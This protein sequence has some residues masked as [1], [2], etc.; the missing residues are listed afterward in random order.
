VK[1]GDQADR[2]AEEGSAW[3]ALGGVALWGL[4]LLFDL[5]GTVKGLRRWVLATAPLAPGVP[6][7]G[8]L[9]AGRGLPLPAGGGGVSQLVWAE[10]ASAA[11][12]GGGV[13]VSG[14]P[15]QP[16]GY[17]NGGAFLAPGESKRAGLI[18]LYEEYGAAGDPRYGV[19]ARSAAVAGARIGYHP[20]TARRELARYLDGRPQSE[21]QRREK[22]VA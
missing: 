14:G 13:M 12:R 4:R 7:G 18:R 15:G 2:G 5:P 9:L 19:R 6:A 22:A 11:R 20:G 3:R 16:P 10:G 17:S 1:A 8:G 21:D